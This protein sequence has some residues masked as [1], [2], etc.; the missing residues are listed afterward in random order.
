MWAVSTGLAKVVQEGF[1]T[2]FNVAG[3]AVRFEDL[4]AEVAG[5]FYLLE[6]L[7]CTGQINLLF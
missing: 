3:I 6:G 4:M 7:Q 2:P 1:I 5:Y